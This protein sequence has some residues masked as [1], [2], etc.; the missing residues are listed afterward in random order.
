MI[1]YEFFLKNI[2]KKWMEKRTISS[3]WDFHAKS[4]EK[5]QAA[6][7]E[8]RLKM[9]ERQ[10]KMAE[11]HAQKMKEKEEQKRLEKIEEFEKHEKG[12]GYYSKLVG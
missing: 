8:A 4:A 3:Q 5:H 2:I 10:N 7:E 11:E 9:Q 12:Q 1:I 6:L